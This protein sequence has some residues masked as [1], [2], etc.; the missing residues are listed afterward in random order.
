MNF[1]SNSFYRAD[2]DGLRAI[3]IL[4]VLAFHAFPNSLPGGFVGVDIFFVIS[5]FLITHIILTKIALNNFSMLEFY[6]RRVKRLFPALMIVL[7]VCLSAGWLLMLPDEY[8]Q[9]GKHAAAGA[10]FFSNLELSKHAI[11]YFGLSA[12]Q[13][14]LLHL[15]SLGIEEQF[16]LLWPMLIILLRKRFLFTVILCALLLSFILSVY[17]V[18]NHPAYAFYMP[19]TRFWEL[20]LGSILALILLHHEKITAY[21][22]CQLRNLATP[23][24]ALVTRLRSGSLLHNAVTRFFVT[25][26]FSRKN[27]ILLRNSASIAGIS[28]IVTAISILNQTMLHPGWWTLLPTIGTLLL[29]LAGP[30]TWFNTK[31]LSHPLLVFIGLISYPLYL[32]HWPLLSFA[33][34]AENGTPSFSTRIMIILISFALAT[35]TY[36]GVEKKIRHKKNFTA[37]LLFV[38]TVAIG[39][40][41]YFAIHT[42][43]LSPA[44][45]LQPH[46]LRATNAIADWQYPVTEFKKIYSGA[47]NIYQRGSHPQKVLFIGDS[48]MQQY[49][50][51][52]NQLINKHGDKVKSALFA[53]RSGCPP[54]PNVKTHQ[55][56]QCNRPFLKEILEFSKDKNIDTIVIGALWTEYL[57]EKPNFYY[58]THGRK[59]IFTPGSPARAHVYAELTDMLQSWKQQGKTVYLV[60][61]MPTGPTFDPHQMFKRNLYGAWTLNAPPYLE[62]AT[63]YAPAKTVVAELKH[64]ATDAGAIM[65]DPSAFLCD[66]TRCATQTDTGALIYKDGKHLRAGYVENYVRYLDHVMVVQ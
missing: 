34:L 10:G 31:V 9:L 16:Y 28:L 65:I 14:P 62:K 57:G 33:H 41:S 51:R 66:K 46:A 64:V 45:M 42:G 5:G 40:F 17:M 22:S 19:M 39:L 18:A 3:A 13:T 50:P 43:K 32:W 48:N 11:N 26:K 25:P 24:L 56:K 44:V 61:P 58:E 36:L 2:I 21:L 4:A 30:T 49:M 52:M 55:R 38:G 53:T 12:N 1:S 6:A 27:L 35:I 37:L 47:V 8:E 60:G 54:L 15:W 7:V 63:W 23:L 20:F 29:I 59:H